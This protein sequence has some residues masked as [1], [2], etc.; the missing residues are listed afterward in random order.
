MLGRYA[1]G[2]ERSESRS[3]VDRLGGYVPERK[4]MTFLRYITHPEVEV[5][6]GSPAHTCER[7]GF[8][9]HPLASIRPVA[10]QRAASARVDTR[11][12]LVTRGTAGSHGPSEPPS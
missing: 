2:E 8:P 4:S 6:L 7:T 11:A 9:G 5:D 1:D 12:F 3:G 10:R